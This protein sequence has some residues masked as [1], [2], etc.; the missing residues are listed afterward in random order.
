MYPYV[1]EHFIILLCLLP[2]SF[3]YERIDLDFDGL[4][5][6]YITYTQNLIDLLMADT[7]LN[8]SSPLWVTSYDPS[9]V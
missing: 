2:D 3:T 8:N 9:I 7:L 6:N 5:R 4:T 1:V